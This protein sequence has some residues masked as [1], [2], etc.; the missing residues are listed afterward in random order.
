MREEWKI[1]LTSILKVICVS[2]IISAAFFLVLESF[3]IFIS[4]FVIATIVQFVI[5]QFIFSYT[6]RKNREAEYVAMQVLKEAAER[7]LP[8]DLT[9]AYC[10]FY[11]RVGVSFSDE[12]VFECTEC[13]KINKIYIQF[14]TA[15]ITY[16][17]TSAKSEDL[18]SDND[19]DMG[20]NQ[21][22]ANDSI[23][24]RKS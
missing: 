21:L 9:C 5:S 13:K 19:V 20:I 3:K 2:A 7:R 10:G 16:P 1:F 18:L 12:N 23:T 11:N 24:I 17:P 14:T 15:R 6:S 8:F 4:I 22:P